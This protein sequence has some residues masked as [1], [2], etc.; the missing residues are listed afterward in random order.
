MTERYRPVLYNGFMDTEELEQ[1]LEGGQETQS[2]EVK[3]AMPWDHKSLAKDIL[4]MSNVRDGGT[5][6]IGVD[7]VSFARQGVDAST[8]NTYKIDI[9]R[10]QM[11]KYAD[12]HVEFSVS[13]PVDR[14]GL[15]YV[16]IRVA[17]FRE[18]PV[19]CRK[20]S[21]DTVA[22]AIYYRCTN[23]RIESATVSNSYDMRDIITIAAMRTRQ[24]LDELSDSTVPTSETLRRRLDE[25]LEGL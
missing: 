4:A 24:R 2:F 19:I 3:A 21:Q 10:D 5:I 13:F 22:G 1:R 9:M 17:P 6:L 11:T 8:R 12:P 15:T 7:D 14:Q 18:I 23:R 25:E 16:A 20:D